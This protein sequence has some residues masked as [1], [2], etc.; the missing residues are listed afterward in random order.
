MLPCQR[1]FNIIVEK[2]DRLVVSFFTG[3]S[4][5]QDVQRVD[6]NLTKIHFCQFVFTCFGM[7]LSNKIISI[8]CTFLALLTNRRKIK[9]MEHLLRAAAI[10]KSVATTRMDASVTIL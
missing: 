6:L 10:S 8:C 4:N 1:L 7:K 5:N 2:Q 3:L 9:R